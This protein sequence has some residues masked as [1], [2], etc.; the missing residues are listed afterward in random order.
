MDDKKGSKNN[1]SDARK[2]R[3]DVRYEDEKVQQ[4]YEK[5]QKELGQIIEK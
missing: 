1:Q 3:S 2:S 5:R 4:A